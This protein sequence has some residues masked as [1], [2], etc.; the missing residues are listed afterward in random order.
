MVSDPGGGHTEAGT[1]GA[2]GDHARQRRGG[3]RR[4]QRNEAEQSAIAGFRAEL[5]QHGREPVDTAWAASTG[6]ALNERLEQA[7]REFGFRVAATDCRSETCSATLT[8]PSAA[9]AAG[10]F[11]RWFP[12]QIDM[13]CSRHGQLDGTGNATVLFTC[14]RTNQAGGESP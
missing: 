1:R 11:P 8:W 6:R 5:L 7:S 10:E 3:R 4:R 9:A 2:L 12:Q 13:R 14:A